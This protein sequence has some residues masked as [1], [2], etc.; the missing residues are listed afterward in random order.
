MKQIAK[1]TGEIFNYLQLKLKELNFDSDRK[2][3][4]EIKQLLNNNIIFTPEEFA[5]ECFYVICVAGFRQD[6]A[7]TICNK[8]VDFAGNNPNF[9][10]NDLL[11]MYKNTMKVKAMKNIW[12]FRAEYQAKFYS[13][14]SDHDQVEFLATLPHI[15]NI[16]KHH[17]ARNLGLNFVK[18]DIWIQRLGVA[19]CGSRDYV[20]KINNKKLEPQIKIFCDTMFNNLAS[21]TGE[22]IGFIDVVLWK[23]CQKK[24]LKID[25]TNIYLESLGV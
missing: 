22:K 5:F 18:Y 3:F 1:I 10:V 7:K 17:L 4:D 13:L 9:E 2:S 16:T 20:G 14:G 12:D 25:G 15:G 21:I 19:L 23:A 8:I 11:A 6:C 24:I